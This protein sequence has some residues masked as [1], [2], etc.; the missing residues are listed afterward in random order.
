[1]SSHFAQERPES[2]GKKVERLKKLVRRFTGKPQRKEYRIWEV[3]FLKACIAS[4]IDK[5][6]E[7]AVVLPCLLATLSRNV[8]RR[9]GMNPAES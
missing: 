3:E 2:L 7:K 6:E 5:N 8:Y 1:M 9:I 4:A